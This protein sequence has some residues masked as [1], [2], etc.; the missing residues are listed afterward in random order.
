MKEVL[1]QC[2]TKVWVIH[3]FVISNETVFLVGTGACYPMRVRKT[4]DGVEMVLEEWIALGICQM[5][6]MYSSLN[7]RKEEDTKYAC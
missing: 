3:A 1:V 2:L 4:Q 5:K 7:S 6:R